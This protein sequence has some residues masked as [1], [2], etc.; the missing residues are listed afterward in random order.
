MADDP[1]IIFGNPD[2]GVGFGDPDTDP[3]IGLGIP[4]PPL[5]Q[6]QRM[7]CPQKI[8]CPGSDNP[9]TNYTSENIPPFVIPRTRGFIKDGYC[10]DG[11]YVSCTSF[12]SEDDAIDCLNR[13]LQQCAICPPPGGSLYTCTAQC[14][15]GGGV[16]TASSNISQ[17]DACARAQALA[18]AETCPPIPPVTE[19]C[20]TQQQCSVSCPDGTSFTFVVPACTVIAAT[21]QE[22]DFIAF[23]LACTRAQ[24]Y[25]MCLADIPRCACVGAA[26]QGT[27]SPSIGG[28]GSITYSVIGS[29]P[30]GLILLQNNPNPRSATIQGTP[31][32]AGTYSF[33]IE[34]ID[35]QGSTMIKAFTIV[36]LQITSLN[37]PDYTVGSPYTAQLTA[38]G[39]GGNYAWKIVAGNLPDGLTMTLSGLIS[40]TPTAANG[41]P[42]TMQVVDQDC[43]AIDKSFI[44][45]RVSLKTVSHTTVATVLGFAGYLS[46]KK[47]HS[48][49]YSGEEKAFYYN[50]G[51]PISTETQAKTQPYLWW[52]ERVVYSGTASI[53]GT[54]HQT[55][56]YEKLKFQGP[57]GADSIPGNFQLNKTVDPVPWPFYGEQVWITD[58]TDSV[59]Q[60]SPS[61]MNAW[62]FFFRFGGVPPISG[63]IVGAPSGI[64]NAWSQSILIILD[65]TDP[66]YALIKANAD[67]LGGIFHGSAYVTSEINVTVTLSNEYTD[68]E[69][70]ANAFK[71]TSNGA[72]AVNR[73]RSGAAGDY[74][75]TFVTV[76]Y[77]LNLSNLIVGQQYSV[78]VDLW[79]LTANTHN[80]TTYLFTATA[81]THSILDSIPKP[82]IGHQVMVR[83]PQVFFA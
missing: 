42:L 13:L 67:A 68:A 70:L 63:P 69:A 29:L 35:S 54:G 19:F 36:I 59:M 40:G 30:D 17:A 72:V 27:V 14:S 83:N 33:S 11:S 53:D 41:T 5:I 26:Y 51:V 6:P 78:E 28:V 21:Q 74:T 79:D 2:T 39:G 1:G 12:I 45:P 71:T 55:S 25:K 56:I 80:P 49:T 44:P 52:L 73:P 15:S 47:Y 38:T 8:T 64:T 57:L 75:S 22:A 81:A 76:D 62:N 16:V 82:L 24:K 34:A 23:N 32:T 61:L 50:P 31:T 10:C 65:P 48:L 4:I 77:T 7:L 46:N 43:E 9:I 66:K 58:D 20:N 37:L 3:Q 60:F 18:A